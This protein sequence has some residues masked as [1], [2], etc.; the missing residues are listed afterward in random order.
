MATGEEAG[1]GTLVAGEAQTSNMDMSF[2][3]CSGN[4]VSALLVPPG[5][6][7][8]LDKALW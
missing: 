6:L 3:L 8:C 7:C 2:P 5:T 1:E 4:D